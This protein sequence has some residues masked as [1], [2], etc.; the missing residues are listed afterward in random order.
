MDPRPRVWLHQRRLF[1]AGCVY[2][3]L[4]ASIRVILLPEPWLHHW[5]VRLHGFNLF[6]CPRHNFSPV[7]LGVHIL[8]ISVPKGMPRKKLAK[9]LEVDLEK[10]GR[11]K[12]G[13]DQDR[14]GAG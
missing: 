13:M 14:E 7:L 2:S 5:I 12:S 3:W 9:F 6:R 1:M 4:D 8:L 11:G 10:E